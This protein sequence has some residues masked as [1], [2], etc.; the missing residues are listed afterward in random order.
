MK[1]RDICAV[2]TVFLMALVPAKAA[3][4]GSWKNP[5]LGVDILLLTVLATSVTILALFYRIR[6]RKYK[7][8]PAIKVFTAICVLFF[9]IC[10]V[11]FI[12]ILV[13]GNP[14]QQT[15][16]VTDT[17]V[18]GNTTNASITKIA[19]DGIYENEHIL[20]FPYP[21]YEEDVIIYLERAD[22]NG[23]GTATMEIYALDNQGN[24]KETKSKSFTLKDYQ[25]NVIRFE[26]FEQMYP[27]YVINLTYNGSSD[28]DKFSISRTLDSC[29]FTSDYAM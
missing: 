5:T 14:D 2:L 24:I 23:N 27:E 22:V 4:W 21:D 10:V 11:G 8:H 26:G 15:H 1:F 16:S 20:F 13:G 7:S 18:A 12:A 25:D 28:L 19:V 29:V 9:I 17:D 6:N 3:T